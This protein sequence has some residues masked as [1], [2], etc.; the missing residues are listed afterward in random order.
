MKVLSKVLLIAAFGTVCALLML[1]HLKSNSLMQRTPSLA[2]LAAAEDARVQ[3]LWNAGQNDEIRMNKQGHLERHEITPDD[4]QLLRVDPEL[5]D[6]V[7]HKA[8]ITMATKTVFHPLSWMRHQTEPKAVGSR[9]ITAPR[10][11]LRAARVQQLWNAAANDKVT[12]GDDG[13]AS[14]PA[15]K[16][17]QDQHDEAE[18]SALRSHPSYAFGKRIFARGEDHGRNYEGDY[19]DDNSIGLKVLHTCLTPWKARRSLSITIACT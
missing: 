6:D 11:S 4:A 17:L 13:D 5:E 8:R 12:A 14:P 16:W 18:T 1:T 2:S 3:A 7:P 19:V 9:T 15:I 10:S